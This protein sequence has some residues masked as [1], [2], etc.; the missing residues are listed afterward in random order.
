VV[1]ARIRP[2]PVAL[3]LLALSALAVT[4]AIALPGVYRALPA[5][6]PDSLTYLEWSPGRTPAYPAFLRAMQTFSRDLALLG[7]VQFAI[8][9]ASAAWCSMT[10]ARCYGHPAVALMFA[11]AVMLHPQLVSY[12]FVT[13]PESLFA[14]AL[15]LS[16]GAMLVAATAATTTSSVA[17]GATLAAAI[18]LK[19]SGY[20]LV[21]GLVAAAVCAGPRAWR[22]LAVSVLT[23]TLALGSVALA[24][25][26][27]YGYFS[28]QAQGGFS[29]LAHVGAFVDPMPA[30]PLA[31][32]SAAIAGDAVPH[33]AA[34]DRIEDLD[35]YYL[36][37][38]H[39]YHVLERIVRRRVGADVEQR[40]GVSGTDER[41]FP[42]NPILLR[43]I[44]AAGSALARQAIANHPGAYVRHVTAQLYGLWFL[45]LFQTSE[46]IARLS[47]A[48]DTVRSSSP[49]LDRSPV[50]FRSVPR[51]IFIAIRSLLAAILIASI[52]AIALSLIFRAP[53][54]MP[55][56][57]AAVALHGTYLL[58]A[59]VQP[60]LPRYA[61]VMWPLAASI[62]A[63]VAVL[64][65]ET[66]WRPRSASSRW[67]AD[68]SPRSN[69]SRGA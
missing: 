9:L 48:L 47:A 40:F 1:N 46:R 69:P 63:G 6:S 33:R 58:V 65:I 38:S 18:L 52:V 11:A 68:G 57:Y 7:P 42:S 14:S 2:Q 10:F 27:R 41:Q 30:G 23:L 60:G 54:D 4:A 66:F 16:L 39:D 31:D 15:L 17:V 51:L 56:V 32:V 20:G 45:P 36:F 34:L 26:V 61:V 12:A 59:A 64:T 13:L 35:T 67:I 3:A 28:T 37:A 19:P 22:F 8:Y 43:E 29:I 50:A 62:A 55:L 25:L 21:G 24:N 49:A 5:L 44:T 53:R